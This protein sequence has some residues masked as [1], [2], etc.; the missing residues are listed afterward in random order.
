M[1]LTGVGGVL[2]PL[3]GDY[4]LM[5]IIFI[6][7]IKMK[8]K[9]QSYQHKF[10]NTIV[11]AFQFLDRQEA[12]ENWRKWFP[13]GGLSIERFADP[14]TGFIGPWNTKYTF[15]KNKDDKGLVISLSELGCF[16]IKNNGEITTEYYG[17]FP[18]FY[19]EID[20]D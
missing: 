19:Q 17:T 15:K 13:E 5:M 3:Y 4:F 1:L 2:R 11:Q 20:H 14:N 18:Q 6:S 12:L 7:I 8:N 16:I 10:N 9:I